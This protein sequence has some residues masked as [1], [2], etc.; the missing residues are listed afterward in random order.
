DASDPVEPEANDP[1]PSDPTLSVPTDDS[2]T[3]DP[4]LT[5][6]PVDPSIDSPT[7]VGPPAVLLD[8]VEF[9]PSELDARDALFRYELRD[10]I[11]QS[12]DDADSVGAQEAR[13]SETDADDRGLPRRFS[14]F[15]DR[16][17]RE[18]G[19]L[20]D[21]VRTDH[22]EWSSEG[23]RPTDGPHTGASSAD[24][25]GPAGLGADTK[26]AILWSLIRSAGSARSEEEEKERR[27]TTVGSR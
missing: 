12:D 14:A 13:E 4:P 21:Q 15:V 27:R 16:Y 5:G 9:E 19:A 10:W 17:E 6:D 1:S 2:P 7:P 24:V 3:S 23:T 18:V 22:P 25:T 8:L 26:A 11:A 20:L